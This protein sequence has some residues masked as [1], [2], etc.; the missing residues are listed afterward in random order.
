ML[1]TKVDA[2]GNFV[3]NSYASSDEVNSIKWNNLEKEEYKKSM[4]IIKG[5]S[6]SAKRMAHYGLHRQRMCGHM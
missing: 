4:R 6:H 2:E 5:S 3:E 1:R